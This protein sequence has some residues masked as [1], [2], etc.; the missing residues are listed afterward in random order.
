M[1][2][3]GPGRRIPWEL[4][5]PKVRSSQAL[6]HGSGCKA[7]CSAGLQRVS[8]QGVPLA[9]AGAFAFTSGVVLVALPLRRLKIGDWFE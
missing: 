5:H 9:L 7:A 8:L 1:L 4:R 2:G 3:L 6:R